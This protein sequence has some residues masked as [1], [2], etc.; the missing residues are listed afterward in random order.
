MNKQNWAGYDKLSF[1]VYGSNDK[2]KMRILLKDNEAEIYESVLIKPDKGKWKK[3]TLDFKTKFKKGRTV[4][5]YGNGIF[6][7]EGVREIIMEISSK[8]A[9]NRSAVYIDE[10][11]LI[12]E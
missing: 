2:V 8:G 9:I 1:Y 11:E 12:A 7:K 10:I 5:G 3:V 6:D 4:A